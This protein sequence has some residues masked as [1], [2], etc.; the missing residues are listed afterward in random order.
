MSRSALLIIVAAAAVLGLP[1]VFLRSSTPS[2]PAPRPR[3]RRPAR[4]PASAPVP[5]E[6]VDRN[7]FEYVDPAP[8]RDP[9]AGRE[10]PAATPS[11]SPSPLAEATPGA[12]E[13]VRLIGLVHRGRE[14]RAALSILGN[15]VILGTGEEA[16]GYR[17]L[18]IDPET[19]V[20]L[21]APDG[22]ER[23][24]ARPATVP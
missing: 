21:R 17:V 23:S 15:V 2:A 10:R 5:A 13:P 7:V 16:E 1:L 6:A 19:G 12:P 9:S 4:P 18:A 22:S 14:L 20:T 24:L 3:E 8:A 11:A